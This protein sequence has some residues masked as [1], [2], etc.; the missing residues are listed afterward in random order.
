MDVEVLR[1]GVLT[2]IGSRGEVLDEVTELD[3]EINCG[4][5][6]KS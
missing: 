5:M 3:R 1:V 4:R 2:T 6:E